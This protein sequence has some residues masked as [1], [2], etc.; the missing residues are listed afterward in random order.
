MADAPLTEMPPAAPGL[1]PLWRNRDFMLLWSGQFVSTLGSGISGIAFPLLV[2]ALTGSPA[3]AGIAGFIFGMPYILLSLPFGALVD[4]WNRKAVMVLCD[5]VRAINAASIPLAA[6]TGHLS[7][8]QLYLTTAVEGTAFVLFN[9]AEV[10]CLPRVVTKEQLPAATGQNQGGQIASGLIASPVGGFLYQTLGQTVPFIA[11]AVSYAVS[12]LSL[13]GIRT[14]FQEERVAQPRDLRR[15][16]GEGLSWLWH[17]PL[18]RYMAFL[19]GGLN[20]VNSALFLV[21]LIL[22]KNMHAPP[23]VIG[24]IFAIQGIGGVLGSLVA[25][26]IQ[27]RFSYA[28]VIVTVVWLQAILLPMFVVAPNPIVLG[29]I[30][31]A[32]FLGIPIYNVVQFSYRV[33]MIPDKLQG[34]VNSTVRLIAFGFNPLGSVL[35]GILIQTVGA[36]ATVLLFGVCMVVM[37]LSVS[38]NRDVRH[39][40]PIGEVVPAG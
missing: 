19:T 8:A 4:R 7:L 32:L 16:I 26:R 30:G 3:K 20:F 13:L 22:A 36:N 40:V 33:A 34:R 21:V 27:R 5:G 11:D 12:V 29:V 9:I 25:S 39:A 2:L 14:E 38:L 37:A 24:I 35:S 1:T 17:Q 6:A 10:A 18:I 28:R 23:D 31:A 15:E